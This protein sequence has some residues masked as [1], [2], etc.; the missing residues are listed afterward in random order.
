MRYYRPFD[1]WVRQGQGKLIRYRCIEV[2]P[3]GGFCVQSKDFFYSPFEDAAVAQLDLQFME[4][5]SEIPPERR[6]G[7]YQ[8]LEEAIRAHDNA[9]KEAQSQE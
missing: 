8:T 6:A 5:L 9:F 3:V 4:L 2:L 1:V 7:L